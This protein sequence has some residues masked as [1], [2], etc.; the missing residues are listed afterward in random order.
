V[1]GRF[2]EQQDLYQLV[3]NVQK[4]AMRAPAAKEYRELHL[5]ACERMARGL[6]DLGILRATR[7]AGGRDAHAPSRTGSGTC[8]ASP[9]MTRAAASQGAPSDTS[10]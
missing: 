9:R 4:A 2:E 7:L 10:G 5:E 8:S 6:V 1:S 3:L